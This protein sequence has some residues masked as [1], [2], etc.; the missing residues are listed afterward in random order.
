[1]SKHQVIALLVVLSGLFFVA[2]FIGGGIIHRPTKQAHEKELEKARAEILEYLQ[3]TRKN[4][5]PL[6][7]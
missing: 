1:M 2:G 6:F 4:E 5:N 3:C 7:V